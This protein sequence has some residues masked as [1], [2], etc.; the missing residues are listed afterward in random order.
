MKELFTILLGFFAIIA[1][2]LSPVFRCMLFHPFKSL[3]N[4]FK[5][6]YKY[7][8]YK[9][10]NEAPFGQIIGYI[11]D[12][13]KK[14]GCGKTLTAVQ[15]LNLLY[16]KYNNK[17]VWC[18][19]RKKMVKQEVL[20][21]SNVKL[22]KVPYLNFVS[23]KQYVSLLK[24]MYESDRENDKVTVIYAFIDEASSLLNS[25]SFKDNLS[26]PVI[27]SL[28]TCRH[29]HSS[30]YYSSQKSRNVDAL[31]RGVTSH[32][33]GCDKFWRYQKVNYY[34]VDEIEYATDPTKVKP[35]KRKCWFIEDK[36]FAKYNTYELLQTIDKKVNENDFMTEE[37]I[38]SHLQIPDPNID[39]VMKPSKKYLKSRKKLNR[40]L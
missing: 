33:E 12:S 22:M 31:L 8:K 6:F 14:F 38:L 37:E 23:L 9:K 36:H 34:D 19:E 28:L 30:L 18:P 25:R 32:Y 13:G 29:Y 5:D 4:G 27:Q 40:K 35:Y 24:E 17:M 1:F 10:W 11:A 3:F 2:I 26:G 16:D 7:I 21:L 15:Y 20:I 39:G